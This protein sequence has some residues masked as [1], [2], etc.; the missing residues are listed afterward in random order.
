ML[1]CIGCAFAGAQVPGEPGSL[2]TLW[3][4]KTLMQNSLWIENPKE[5]KFG[6]G[7]GTVVI[8]DIKGPGMITMI[9]FALPPSLRMGRDTVLR[10]FWDG[11]TNPSVE[12]PLVDFFCDP[13]GSLEH[14][15]SALVNKMRGWNAWFEMPF[16]KSARVEVTNDNPRYPAL[17]QVNPCYAYVMYRPLKKVAR[18]MAYFHAHWRQET[19][20]LGRNEYEVFHAKGR[21]HFI[22]WN[23]TVRGAEPS[24]PGY[25]VDENEK[26]FVDGE[27]EA[28]IEWQGLEDSFGFSW[29]FPEKGGEFPFTGYQP[30]YTG[31]AAAYRFCINDRIPF[32]KTIRMTVGF[33]KN[34]DKMFYEM[35]SKPENPLQFSSVAYWYQ[36]EPHEAY[37]PLPSC[38]ERATALPPDGKPVD[39]SKYTAEHES[40]VLCCGRKTGDIDYLKEGWDFRFKNGFAYADWKTE[41]P[42]CWASDKE[43]LA[44]DLTCPK[45]A[46]G[47]LRMFILDG[48]NFGGGR[49]ET[50]NV[51]GRNVGTFENFQ[52]GRWVEVPIAAAD[53]AEGVIPVTIANA[54]TGANVVVSLVRFVE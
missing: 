45:G 16:A 24:G 31:G 15:S 19:L 26:F 21:G 35:F 6:E 54:R 13:D 30:F 47:T 43:P 10:I 36:K 49:K 38:R 17:W 50:I 53:T 25:P 52:Q 20:L 39:V 2:C 23:V 32:R 48:D 5:L 29:G 14:V 22:G 11:E 41:V 37:P 1:A 9:H 12:S 28:S 27:P 51:A 8:A 7:R 42:H 4:G 34:E 3:P 46:S 33:G 40:V 18:N 44:F